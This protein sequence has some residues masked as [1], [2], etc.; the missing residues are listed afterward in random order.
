MKDN[1]T[2]PHTLYTVYDAPACASQFYTKSNIAEAVGKATGESEEPA[3]ASKA[4]DNVSDDLYTYCICP[5]GFQLNF[6]AA[7][8]RFPPG[9]KGM[10]CCRAEGLT[11]VLTV[12]GI[13]PYSHVWVNERPEPGSSS[14]VIGYCPTCGTIHRDYWAAGFWNRWEGAVRSGGPGTTCYAPAGLSDGFD[15]GTYSAFQ[16]KLEDDYGFHWVAYPYKEWSDRCPH[17][18]PD[19]FP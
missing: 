19:P 14:R 10:C 8:G 7:M 16:T 1:T 17:N 2:G 13:G 9:F 3:I 18:R 11:C 6:D 5:D 15:E 12:L 4:N